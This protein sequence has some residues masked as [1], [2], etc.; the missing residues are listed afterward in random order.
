MRIRSSFLIVV[1]LCGTAAAQNQTQTRQQ[2]LEELQQILLP[3]RTPPTGRINA[4]DKTWEDWVKRTGELPPDFDS[5]PSL[6]ELSDP[7]MLD[8]DGRQV[9]VTTPEHWLRKKQW[10][11]G[12]VERWMFGTMPP[13]PYNLRSRVDRKSTR[14]N[15][16]HTT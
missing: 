1:F 6:A 7:L 12:Q 11:R 5:M 2:V 14:L 10:I 13:R 15:S 16:S 8:E 3:S 9:P 4:T